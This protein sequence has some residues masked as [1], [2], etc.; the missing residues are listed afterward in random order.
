MATLFI[1][2]AIRIFGHAPETY[3]NLVMLFSPAAVARTTVLK[4]VYEV[5]PDLYGHIAETAG[6]LM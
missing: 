4:V 1:S 6:K 3:Q 5:N 2:R